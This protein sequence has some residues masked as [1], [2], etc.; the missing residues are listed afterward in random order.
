[1]SGERTIAAKP[2]DERKVLRRNVNQIP[3]EIANDMCLNEKIAA[4]LPSNYNFEIH[5]IIWRLKQANVARVALQFPEGLIIF[6]TSIAEII[7]AFLGIEVIILGDVTY[8]ACCV[9][10]YVA[11]LNGCTFIIHFA[12][13]CLVPLNIMINSIKVLYIFVDIKFDIFHCINTIKANFN[14][15]LNE[16]I[17]MSS[18][19]QFV[20]SIHSIAKVLKNDHNY[21][22]IIPSVKPLSPGEV[23]GCTSPKLDSN[24]NKIIFVADGRFHL[25]SI[26]INNPKGKEFYKYNPY[27]KEITREYYDFDKMIQQREHAISKAIDVFKR[28]GT[29]GIIL[30]TLGRQG[31]A[32]VFKS[33][34][35]KIKLKANHCSVIK[36]LIPEIKPHLLNAFED[37][38]D[39]WVQTSCPRLSIDWGNDFV[40]KPLLTTYELNLALNLVK[41]VKESGIILSERNDVSLY[42][43]DF[44]ATNSLGNWTPNHKCNSTCSCNDL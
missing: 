13:S 9:D 5:K 34:E 37:S 41:G 19:I 16:P 2:Y 31:N 22:M 29:I 35:N 44:Y 33:I 17:A 42:P 38:I 23:L 18:T 32:T 11:S 12:H 25:E 21:N 24:V 7:S 1:M 20:S 39:I 36:I 15:E 3:E 6:A 30:G 43:M 26:M 10:D 27:N 14:T 8:G 4:L 28:N 40:H